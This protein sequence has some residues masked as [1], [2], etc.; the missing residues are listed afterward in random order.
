MS[1]RVARYAVFVTACLASITVII[2]GKP[3]Q[4]VSQT[5][6]GGRPPVPAY[7]HGSP[8]AMVAYLDFG[9]YLGGGGEPLSDADVYTVFSTCAAKLYPQLGIT[10]TTIPPTRRPG[11]YVTVRF[12]ADYTIP[13]RVGAIGNCP[14]KAFLNTSWWVPNVVY[15]ARNTP[16]SMGVVAAHEVVHCL[17]PDGVSHEET[18]VGNLPNLM[19]ANCPPAGVLSPNMVLLVAGQIDDFNA[20]WRMGAFLL[21][22]GSWTFNWHQIGN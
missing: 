14:R 4:V 18:P 10:V 15:V 22:S 19:G 16:A 9:D 7:A 2:S 20:G 8:N 21:P 13:W 1:H 6:P 5:P 12:L 3:C 11:E 17:Q